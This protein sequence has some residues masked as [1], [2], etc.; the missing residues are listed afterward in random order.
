MSLRPC[1]D[2]KRLSQKGGNSSH[3][4]EH[5]EEPCGDRK[6]L[7]LSLRLK[8]ILA[9]RDGGEQPQGSLAEEQRRGPLHFPRNPLSGSSFVRPQRYALDFP[10]LQEESAPSLAP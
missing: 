7:I 4:T 9:R 6:V 8:R 5:S 1:R 3:S 10:L 2:A